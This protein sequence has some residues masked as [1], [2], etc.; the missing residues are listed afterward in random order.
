MSQNKVKNSVL[1]EENI[2][3]N[4]YS[5]VPCVIG[6]GRKYPSITK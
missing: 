6:Q 1:E 2:E 3:T 5:N 4:K